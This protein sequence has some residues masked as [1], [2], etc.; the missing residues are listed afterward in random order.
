MSSPLEERRSE[1]IDYQKYM[2]VLVFNVKELFTSE[3][4]SLKLQIKGLEDKLLIQ[5]DSHE[6]DSQ[7]Q[8]DEFRYDLGRVKDKV[9]DLDLRLNN[10]EIAPIK[11]KAE[12]IDS[13][14][15]IFKKIFFTVVATGLVGIIVSI[16]VTNIKGV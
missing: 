8:I 5:L 6:R 9:V 1:A 15:L 12:N 11:S 13:F 3:V 16:I 10:L 14:F 4:S 2:E 7:K